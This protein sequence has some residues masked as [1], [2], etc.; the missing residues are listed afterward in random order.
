MT[1]FLKVREPFLNTDL[2]DLRRDATALNSV[3]RTLQASI[4]HLYKEAPSAVR[5]FS[6]M[7]LFDHDDIPNYLVRDYVVDEYSESSVKSND[8][9][10]QAF[11]ET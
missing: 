6:L 2:P 7:S 4:D 3:T 8:E 11:R 5:L 1:A 9:L 10:D